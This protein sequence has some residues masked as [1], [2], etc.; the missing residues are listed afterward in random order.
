M[1]LYCALTAY[2]PVISR[3]ILRVHKVLSAKIVMNV[4]NHHSGAL[5]DRSKDRHEKCTWFL[6]QVST[7]LDPGIDLSL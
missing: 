6:E 1:S 3:F 5:R 2:N 7:A 4:S